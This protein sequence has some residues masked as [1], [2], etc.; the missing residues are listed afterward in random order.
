MEKTGTEKINWTYKNVD[1]L[2]FE[3]DRLN[4]SAVSRVKVGDTITTSDGVV[5]KRIDARK[6]KVCWQRSEN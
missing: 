6:H 4:W 1:S 2:A 5:F 3:S